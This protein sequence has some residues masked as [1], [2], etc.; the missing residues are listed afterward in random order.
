MLPNGLAAATIFIGSMTAGRIVSPINLL[1]QD[2]VL[3]Y[4][5]AH[6]APHAIFVAPEFF[7]R[8]SAL[9]ARIGLSRRSYRPT[10]T[11]SSCRTTR[12]MTLT[13]WKAKA[14]RC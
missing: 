3:E 4:T 10:P 7:D 2:A 1:A 6:A 9:V 12:P 14:R 8:L 13:R 11:A 5:L